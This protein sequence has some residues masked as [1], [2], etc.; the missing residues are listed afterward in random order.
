MTPIEIIAL[1]IA[2][3]TIGDA[4]TG[5]ARP[6]K[7]LIFLTKSLRSNFAWVLSL[8]LLIIFLVFGYFINQQLTIIQIV[9]GLFLGVLLTKFIVSLHPKE[10]MPLIKQIYTKTAWFEIIIDLI[11]AGIVFWILFAH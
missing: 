7:M 5:F 10:L 8:G 11:F 9:P 3:M 1:I 2:I 6:K 4:I